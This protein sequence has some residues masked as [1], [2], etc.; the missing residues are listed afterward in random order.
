MA[1]GRGTV[2]KWPAI[3]SRPQPAEGG[4]ST[5]DRTDTG[6]TTRWVPEPA[7]EVAWET[8]SDTARMGHAGC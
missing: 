8:V 1:H 3:C 6:A 4:I 2:D 5:A 7:E